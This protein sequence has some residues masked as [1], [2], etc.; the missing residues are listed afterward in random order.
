MNFLT[1]GHKQALFT[2][3]DKSLSSWYSHAVTLMFKLLE[4]TTSLY[5]H[6]HP[7]E[8]PDPVMSNSKYLIVG[9]Y[10]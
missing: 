3:Q 10:V 9:Q 1:G 7:A 4:P 6:L 5:K 2:K 8:N